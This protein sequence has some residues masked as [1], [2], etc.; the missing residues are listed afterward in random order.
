MTDTPTIQPTGIAAVTAGISIFFCI[1][2]TITLFLRIWVRISIKAL[3]MDDYLMIIGWVSMP[4]RRPTPVELYL[5]KLSGLLC[6]MRYLF[7]HGLLDRPG[8]P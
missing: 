7:N 4:R 6:C 8:F 2:S 5:N 3:G 1:A